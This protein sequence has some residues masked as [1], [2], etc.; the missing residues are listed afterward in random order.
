[1]QSRQVI[2]F[3]LR[4]GLFAS[5]ILVL[6]VYYFIL[7]PFKVIYSYDQYFENGKS[8]VVTQNKGYISTQTFLKQH[9]KEAY[10]SFIF[11]SSRTLF[12]RIENWRK[13]LDSEARCFHMD[14]SG[15]SI[16]AIA[17]KMEFLQREGAEIKNALLVLDEEALRQTTVPPGHIFVLHPS[18]D[19]TVGYMDF[20]SEFLTTYFRPRFLFGLIDYQISG[21]M[22]PY[23]KAHKL[24]IDNEV[25]YDVRINEMKFTGNDRLLD[26]SMYYTPERMKVFHERSKQEATGDTIIREEHYKLLQQIATIFKEEQTDYRVVISPLYN[27]VKLNPSDLMLLKHL[28]GTDRVFDFSG[29]NEITEDYRN[30]Y[31]NSHYLP[32]VCNHILEEVYQRIK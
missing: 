24:L 2:R 18:V 28:F 23:M 16:Y 27:Q 32:S 11:G 14:G 22:K 17:R 7:D 10:N 3:F 26:Q 31:E 9:N 12:Y 1:M 19:S 4:A 6:V 20:H 30:Y 13:Y 8:N 29:K 15:E 21:E 25:E 5:P